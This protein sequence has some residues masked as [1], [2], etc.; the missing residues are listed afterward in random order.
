MTAATGRKVS[1][2]RAALRDCSTLAN[3]QYQVAEN[4]VEH[5]NPLDVYLGESDNA[6]PCHELAV[7]VPESRPLCVWY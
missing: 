7:G 3:V 2:F 4:P 5:V 6:L 1:V